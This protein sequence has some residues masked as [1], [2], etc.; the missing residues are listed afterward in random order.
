MEQN[1]SF[2]GKQCINKNTFHKNTRPIVTDKVD[3]RRMV[4]SKKDSYGKKGLLRYFIGYIKE[5]DA[6]PVPLFMKVPHVNRY[7][8]YFDSKNSCVNLSVHE[9]ELLKKYNVIWDHIWFDKF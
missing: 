7:V 3:V 6:F 2:I 8:K 9:K 5:T 1:S 4:L